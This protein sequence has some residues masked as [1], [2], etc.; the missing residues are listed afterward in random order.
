MLLHPLLCNTRAGATPSNKIVRSHLTV[1]LSRMAGLMAIANY[2]PAASSPVERTARGQWRLIIV[3]LTT[4]LALA[5]VALATAETTAVR[6]ERLYH[7]AQARFKE[8]GTNLETGWQFAQACFDFAELATRD[9]ARAA[10]AEEGISACQSVLTRKYSS[11]PAHYYLALNLGQLARTKSVGALKLVREME[12]EFATAIELDEKLDYAGPHRSLGLLY[13]EAPGWP[14]SIG[15]R[16]KARLHLRRAVDLCPNLP[17][18]SLS[19]LEA[20]VDWGELRT[21]TEELPALNVTFVSARKQF[22]GE[23]WVSS[24]ADWDA[25]LE[26]LKSKVAL[27]SHRAV[28]PR[29]R[30][31]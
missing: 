23:K 3:L 12:A 19:L 31:P 5:S 10:I 29:S 27:S 2:S 28:S 14:T 1:A 9:S 15:N 13:K 11:A 22:T 20:Y 21:V 18:N 17:D 7:E 24:W 30:G 25:R 8:S 6:I 16:V 26:K 4:F